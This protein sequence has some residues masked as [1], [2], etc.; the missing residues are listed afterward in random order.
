M[1][2]RR[3]LFAGLAVIAVTIG[4]GGLA[5]ADNA[6][7]AAKHAKVEARLQQIRK[8]VKENQAA[9]RREHNDRVEDMHGVG[10]PTASERIARSGAGIDNKQAEI[11]ARI[12]RGIASGKLTR[13]EVDVIRRLQTRVDKLEARFRGNDGSLS[14][15]ERK[16]LNEELYLLN[17]DITKQLND[18]NIR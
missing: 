4:N 13:G 1:N 16:R 18:K 15:A 8:E 12:Q 10:A 14:A 5:L 2:R 11:N 6:D 17:F 7:Q 9:A 3:E